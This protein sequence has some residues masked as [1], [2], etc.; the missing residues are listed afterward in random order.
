MKAFLDLIELDKAP[1]LNSKPIW[2]QDY[3]NIQMLNLLPDH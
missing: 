3:L 1:T 2:L